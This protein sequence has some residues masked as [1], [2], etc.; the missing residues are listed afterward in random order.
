MLTISS[1]KNF[2]QIDENVFDHIPHS[3]ILKGLMSRK[4]LLHS[5]TKSYEK[6]YVVVINMYLKLFKKKCT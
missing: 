6:I 2:R 1:R 4:L 5:T 3:H